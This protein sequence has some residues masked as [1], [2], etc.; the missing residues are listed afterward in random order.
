MGVALSLLWLT[1]CYRDAGAYGQ[2][3]HQH[4]PALRHR[5]R[6]VGP[7]S[8]RNR[9]P[10]RQRCV[11]DD[12]AQVRRKPRRETPVLPGRRGRV[13]G[14]LDIAGGQGHVCQ[15]KVTYACAD[16]AEFGRGLQAGVCRGPGGSS[17]ALPC[18]RGALVRGASGPARW[19]QMTGITGPT[20]LPL[21]FDP[22]H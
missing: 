14:R 19:K 10:A 1:L 8:G 6:V 4:G 15:C 3:P 2:R 13:Q 18:Q 20:T 11:H 9:I 7:A 12:G 17:V 16:P 5:N 22:G 21:E